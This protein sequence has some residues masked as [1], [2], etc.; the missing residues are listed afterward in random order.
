MTSLS[1]RFLGQPRLTKPTL[2]GAGGA[3]VS[4]MD[5]LADTGNNQGAT[6]ILAI[7]AS[8]LLA[9][10]RP[11]HAE[12]RAGMGIMEVTRVMSRST[13]AVLPLLETN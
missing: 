1:T 11:N 3:A 9:L 8:W 6:C 13:D 4:E 12:Q 5:F 2:R 10:G 7:L